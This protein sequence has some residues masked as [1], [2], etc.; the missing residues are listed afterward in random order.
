[1]V[2]IKKFSNIVCKEMEKINEKINEFEA[3]IRGEEWML[4]AVYM[5]GKREKIFSKI[6]EDLERN[7]GRRVL[8][9][10]D[11]NS[12]SGRKKGRRIK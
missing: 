2:A 6:R 11:F 7:P 12:R 4:L 10:E 5:K 1:M 9:G 3:E 8:I